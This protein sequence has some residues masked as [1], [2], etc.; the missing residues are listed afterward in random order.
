MK[1]NGFKYICAIAALVYLVSAL[2]YLVNALV[3]T[4]FIGAD[5]AAPSL[6]V[7]AGMTADFLLFGAIFY[8]LQ[9]RKLIYWRLIPVLMVALLMLHLGF[10]LL[11]YIRH[12]QPWVPFVSVI[13]IF[14]IG[15]LIFMAWW[16]N[17]KSYFA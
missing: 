7:P 12:S 15:F 13:V 3:P 2:V 1:M 6:T 8:G 10:P 17:Q 14:V 5:T 16:R 4:P 11:Y 9:K